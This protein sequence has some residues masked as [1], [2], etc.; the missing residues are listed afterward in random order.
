[1]H[2]VHMCV[3]ACMHMCMCVWCF[4]CVG[5]WVGKYI[6]V[7]EGG[8]YDRIR[9]VIYA[10]QNSA[11]QIEASPPAR[12]QIERSAKGGGGGGWS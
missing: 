5:R 2:Y 4:L 10:W 6:C 3:C 11:I 7:T 9:R 8:G 1:M 12:M